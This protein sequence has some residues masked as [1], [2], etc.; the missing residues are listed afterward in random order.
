MDIIHRLVFCLKHSASETE[1]SLR[2][3]VVHIRQSTE[4]RNV[5][6]NVVH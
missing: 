2:F 6:Q 5:F 3:Q 1:F 4:I